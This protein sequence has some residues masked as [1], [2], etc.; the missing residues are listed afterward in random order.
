M[1][2]KARSRLGPNGSRQYLCTCALEPVAQWRGKSAWYDHQ[3]QCS[4][5]HYNSSDLSDVEVFQISGTGGTASA[6]PAMRIRRYREP[7][8]HSGLVSAPHPVSNHASKLSSSSLPSMQ[9]DSSDEG[10]ESIMNDQE[11]RQDHI[12]E[13][14][15]RENTDDTKEADHE[16][17]NMQVLAPPDFLQLQSPPIAGRSAGPRLEPTR[18]VCRTS[19]SSQCIYIY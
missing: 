16:A 2:P 13:E 5:F 4:G 15:N 14:G 10:E 9:G 3:I 19:V 1:S 17:G 6:A 7:A 12:S 18:S 11:T 8:S